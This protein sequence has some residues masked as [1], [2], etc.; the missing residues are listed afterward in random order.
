MSDP[1]TSGGEPNPSPK[2]LNAEALK[3]SVQGLQRIYAF[4]I[5]LAFT[6]ALNKLFITSQ[7]Q[8]PDLSSILT[9]KGLLFLSF[10][11][12]IVPFFH[13]MN[14]HLD[15]VYAFDRI[16]SSLGGSL[17][18]PRP[19]SILLDLFVFVVEASLL[20]LLAA[21]IADAESFVLICSILLAVDCA[22]AFTTWLLTKS[23]VLKWALI[24]LIASPFLFFAK[25]LG[26]LSPP[27]LL[28]S[29]TIILVS[30]TVVDY[31]INWSFYLPATRSPSK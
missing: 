13:G 29:V 2:D 4:I 17:P 16:P 8:A 19:G 25:G 22:W 27:L 31:W 10:L 11:S 7:S 15:E 28:T 5:A 23:P 26:A 30:R 9:S 6:T 12:T 20:F 1:S 24:N 14:R 18:P 3:L 21:A